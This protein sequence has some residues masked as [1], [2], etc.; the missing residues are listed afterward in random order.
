MKYDPPTNGD[1]PG[2][3]AWTPFGTIAFWARK[4]SMHRNTLAKHLKSGAVV[5]NRLGRL[6]QLDA[7]I[8]PAHERAKY[9]PPVR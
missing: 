8:L 7:A 3:V 6:V 4:L 9:S 1:R 5:S 2:G